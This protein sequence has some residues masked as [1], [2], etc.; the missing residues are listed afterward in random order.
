MRFVLVPEGTFRM[1][2][3]KD[4]PGR[5]S[6]E[7]AIDVTITRPYY[8]QTTEVTVAQAKE[9][10]ADVAFERPLGTK[11]DGVP[12]VL[13]H[14]AAT[15][16]ARR[17]C[18]REP[19]RR[20]RLPTDAEWE[21]ACRAGT[22]TAYSFGPTISPELARFASGYGGGPAPPGSYPA[23]AWGLHEMHGNVAEWCE[24]DV[25]FEPDGGPRDP[26][27]LGDRSAVRRGGSWKSDRE[28]VRSAYRWHGGIEGGPDDV[29]VRL[30]VDIDAPPPPPDGLRVP[31]RAEA[32]DVPAWARVGAEQRRIA[33]EL[34]VPVAFSNELGM[35]FVLVPPGEFVMGGP[36]FGSPKDPDAPT[37]HSVTLTRAF[38]VQAS[39]V[40]NAHY[41]HFDPRHRSDS[42]HAER[43]WNDDGNPAVRLSW[44][45]AT[46]FARWLSAGKGSAEHRLP[47]EAEWEWACRAGT[48][49]GWWT[50]EDAAE[51]SRAERFGD[52][53]RSAQWGFATFPIGGGRPNP[54]GVH[55]ML[56][57]V[58]EWCAD[59]LGPYPS[60]P[61][62]DPPGGSRPAR[63]GA[64]RRIVRGG[65]VGLGAPTLVSAGGRGAA[66]PA[67]RDRSV[68]FR[69]VIPLPPR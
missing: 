33:E 46:A 48:T 61:V 32:A 40:A 43:W 52:D 42:R 26:R 16:L 53:A 19:R 25:V 14:D 67:W 13:T 63:A 35:G 49:G 11:A 50:G 60:G 36:N 68:G 39:E 44:H 6:H 18:D 41:R 10:E 58:R 55:D 38:Y 56:G 65:W 22:T 9:F 57:N 62:S 66:D 59:W 5:E 8:V 69:V 23:N 31:T 34:G 37:L 27:V 54:F 4:E 15:A 30:V 47:T 24:D 51:V 17:L 12:A 28:R 21:R 20:Y 7:K 1:G 29:G 3:P 64:G 2:S 45:D